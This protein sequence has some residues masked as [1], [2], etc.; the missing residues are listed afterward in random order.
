M[1]Q[2]WKQT[3]YKNY[4]VSNDGL[5][6]SKLNDCILAQQKERYA[7]V[8]I[9]DNGICITQLVHRL[10]AEAF[11]EKPDGREAVNHIDGNRLNNCV[12]N[13]EWCTPQENKTHA[14]ANGLVANGERINTARLTEEQAK[15]ALLL[16]SENVSSAEIGRLFNV[17]RATISKLK[18]GITWKHLSRDGLNM[19]TKAYAKKLRSE[20][21]IEIKK[22]IKDG[23]CDRTIADIF[24]VAPGT[25]NQIRHNKTWRNI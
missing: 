8:S 12:S 7:R 21:V 20:D 23:T 25:I 1:Q 13:L 17:T 4:L 10:V 24:N 19:N 9:Y 6:Y 16:L 5:V 14:V 15:Q 2:L 18:K 11:I 22:L 3:K